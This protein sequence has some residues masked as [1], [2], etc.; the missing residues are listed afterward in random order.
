M[1]VTP[2]VDTLETLEAEVANLVRQLPRLKHGDLIQR[3]IATL[4]R[5]AHSE[6]DRLDWKILSAS[7]L[8]MEAGFEVFHRYR[9]IRKVTVFGSARLQPETPE[10]QMAVHFSR[11]IAQKGFMVMTGAGGGIMQAGN[12][13]AG[14]H[15][16]FG[17]NIRLPFEQEA[18]PYIAGDEKLIYFK[19]FFTRKL[20]L[21]RESD[22]IALFPGGFGTQDEAFECLTLAQ[23]GRYGP[24]PLVLIDCPG[25]RYWHG[26]NDY[27][28][29]HL[30]KQGL[31]SPDDSSLY[32]ITDN[33]DV[34]CEAIL[35]FY[36]VYHSS[37]YVQERLV[38][39]LK[40]ELTA[41]QVV[42]LNDRF[43]GIIV[44]GKIE[45]SQA[46]PQE[47]GDE[48]VLLPRLVLHFNQRDLGRLY[49]MIAVINQMGSTAPE[50]CH[51]EEK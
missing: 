34:A 22:A 44:H 31:I 32:T 41:E 47:A 6:A 17:L 29:D 35:G 7:L 50:S 5:I 15:H 14:A 24:A 48:T 3:A 37:R 38:I 42:E 45:K 9:H 21:L 19:Y 27:V 46:L 40:T 43:S 28:Q 4:A 13:G 26:W 2:A 16:S 10:Y 18:N 30:L 36:R 39:R 11:H 49:Q 51:P 20:F 25:G 23:T 8:D 1:A 12:E 33:L